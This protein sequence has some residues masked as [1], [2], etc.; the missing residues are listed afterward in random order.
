M[1]GH[2]ACGYVRR[3]KALA[4]NQDNPLQTVHL[5]PWNLWKAGQ[6][7][8]CS[9][10]RH[11]EPCAPTRRAVWFA[12]LSL[13]MLLLECEA[14]AGA[15]V[16]RPRP[17]EP[18]LSLTPDEIRECVESIAT[19]ATE[20]AAR[21]SYRECLSSI[22]ERRRSGQL[23]LDAAERARDEKQYEECILQKRKR[24]LKIMRPYLTCPALRVS[25]V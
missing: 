9:P 23:L 25:P 7:P 4:L 13:G 11:G 18:K 20:Y 22:R 3:Q 5:M 16:L 19:I 21:M 10:C 15:I 24:R 6:Q 12:R 2:N 8:K 1:V 14:L 17:E